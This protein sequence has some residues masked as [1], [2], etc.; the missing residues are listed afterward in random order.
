[1]AKFRRQKKNTLRVVNPY[2]LYALLVALSFVAGSTWVVSADFWL[3]DLKILQVS[4]TCACSPLF[5][6]TQDARRPF[7]AAPPVSTERSP[8]IVAVAAAG[9][10]YMVFAN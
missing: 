9:A 4:W 10:V 8:I 3:Q 1:M 5:F 7:L 2:T 6:M